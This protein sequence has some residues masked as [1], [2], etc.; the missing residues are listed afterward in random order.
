MGVDG[1]DSVELC[2]PD[3]YRYL[4]LEFD[5]DVLVGANSLGLTEHVGALRGLIQG[6]VRL[7][8]WK[9]R[10]MNDPNRIVEAY[11]AKNYLASA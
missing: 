3:A 1:G 5:N 9:D 8:D 10:L 11:L 7:G 2:N 6:K 4:R